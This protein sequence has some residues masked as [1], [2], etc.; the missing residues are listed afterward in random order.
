MD[1]LDVNDIDAKENIDYVICPICGIRGINLTAH[2]RC[3]H[4]F[5]G[6]QFYKKY[7]NNKLMCKNYIKNMKE[8]KSKTKEYRSNLFKQK[9]IN[10]ELKICDSNKN[11]IGLGGF[12]KDIGHYCRS[13]WEANYARLLNYYNIEYDYEVKVPLYK[14]DGTLDT[15]YV[16]DFYLKKLDIYVEIKGQWLDSAKYKVDL[17]IK[18][19]GKKLLIIDTNKYRRI[20]NYF[21]YKIPLWEYPKHNIKTHPET[22]SLEKKEKNKNTE[23]CPICGKYFNK[24]LLHF[25]LESKKDKNHKEEFDKH[26]NKINNLFFDLSID[27]NTNFKEYSYIFNTYDKVYNLWYKTYSKEELKNRRLMKNKK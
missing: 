4:G 20:E 1:Y 18:Q 24:I 3:K 8:T 5:N 21:I 11:G 14:E 6:E 9:F 10:G 22:Y 17:F 25:T 13:M 15:I 27:K 2:V 12:R 26:I 19:T 23:Q 16:P 7:P